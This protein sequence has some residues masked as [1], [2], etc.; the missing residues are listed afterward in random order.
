MDRLH[1]IRA[2]DD[3]SKAIRTTKKKKVLE[4]LQEVLVALTL[5]IHDILME[6]LKCPRLDD[7]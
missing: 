2:L 3:I 4:E 5:L 6:D 1:T 7:K